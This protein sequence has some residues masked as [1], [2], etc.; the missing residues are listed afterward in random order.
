[1]SFEKY[2]LHDGFC[3]L[4]CRTDPIKMK[5]DKSHAF[6]ACSLT[7]GN[8]PLQLSKSHMHLLKLWECPA[9]YYNSEADSMLTLVLFEPPTQQR[10]AVCQP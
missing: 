2:C 3:F 1:M 6:P 9:V 4:A 7:T 8:S 5:G 10:F